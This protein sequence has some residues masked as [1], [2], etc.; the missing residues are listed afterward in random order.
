MKTYYSITLLVVLLIG[1]FSCSIN[2]FQ[3]EQY[4]QLA[5]SSPSCLRAFNDLTETFQTKLTLEKA[6]KISAPGQ[7]TYGRPR[8]DYLRHRFQT[9]TFKEIQEY[10]DTKP[11]PYVEDPDGKWIPHDRHHLFV[12]LVKER[13]NLKKR[14]PKRALKITYHRK[15]SFKDRAWPE[16]RAYMEENNL[17]LLR[18]KGEVI[19]WEDL[20]KSF[21]GMKK[22]FFRGMAYILIKAGYIDKEPIPF[23]EFLWADHLRR[24]F[25]NLKTQWN[26][27]NI[28]IVFQD[29]IQNPSSYQ[30]LPGLSPTPPSVEE[31]FSQIKKISD[32]LNW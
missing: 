15:I 25:P 4:R 26:L 6:N 31:G 9:E 1:G 16:Y 12:A 7:S 8:V 5:S 24:R 23:F 21:T 28:E 19:N 32:A 13:E 17:V 20:P 10:L 27:Q 30:K 2:P 11:I 29:L 22:D 14:F 18:A 3:V